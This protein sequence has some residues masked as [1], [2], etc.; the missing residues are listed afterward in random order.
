MKKRKRHGMNSNKI[1][2]QCTE[3]FKRQKVIDNLYMR[4]R[5][6]VGSSEKRGEWKE[7]G[8]RV[9]R[10]MFKSSNMYYCVIKKKR[11]TSP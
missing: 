10:K 6:C 7:H 2:Y 4:K 3:R 11:N 8:F 9:V 1:L 5:L